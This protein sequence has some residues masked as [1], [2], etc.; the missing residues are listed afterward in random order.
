MATTTDVGDPLHDPADMLAAREALSVRNMNALIAIVE[1]STADS[2][3]RVAASAELNKMLSLGILNRGRVERA[4]QVNNFRLGDRQADVATR[5]LLARFDAPQGA[6][7]GADAIAE[8]LEA[9]AYDDTE[10]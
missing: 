10:A 2:R 8:T 5:Q 4:T 6:P 3:A 1:D 9:V 7:A